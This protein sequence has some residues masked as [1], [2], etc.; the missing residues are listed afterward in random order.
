MVSHP[1]GSGQYAEIDYPFDKSVC[2]HDKRHGGAFVSAARKEASSP[3]I[4]RFVQ[5]DTIIPDLSNPQSWNRYS[6]VTNRPVNFN[7][8][9]GH[10]MDDGD[11]GGCTIKCKVTV[12]SGEIKRS[13]RSDF[14]KNALENLL[15]A[16]D[17]GL[18][19][20]DYVLQNNVSIGFH[21]HLYA[22]AYWDDEDNALYLNM[23]QNTTRPDDPFV[24]NLIAHEVTHLEQGSTWAL[25]KAGEL[26]AWKAGFAVENYFRP[27]NEGSV[28]YKIV[29]DLDVSDI[30]TFT[31]LVHE[32][33]QNAVGW[34]GGLYNL[35][36]D[37]LPDYPIGIML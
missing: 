11:D 4:N 20:V 15:N 9:T 3:Y 23:D 35:F 7:D 28:G 2:R 24:L 6:Y 33:N 34:S 25:T 26:E 13:K 37:Q 14:D 36:F 31:E 1:H 21:W 8:P 17:E 12:L 10:V 18:H 5:P 30:D 19:V 16:G 22:G 29:N 27:L 32:Y